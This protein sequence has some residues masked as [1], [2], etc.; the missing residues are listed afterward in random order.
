MSSLLL[1][2]LF[3]VIIALPLA[4]VFKFIDSIL[5]V[6]LGLDVIGELL[7]IGAFLLV[8]FLLCSILPS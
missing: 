8:T 3:M 1:F 7:S 4:I 2:C 5:E 6:L